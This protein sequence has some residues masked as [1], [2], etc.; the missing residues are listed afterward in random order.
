MKHVLLLTKIALTL[1][2]LNLYSSPLL[3]KVY[4]SVDEN[5][6]EHYTDTPNLDNKEIKVELTPHSSSGPIITPRKRTSTN[7]QTQSSKTKVS[8]SSPSN[9]QSVRAN[10]GN[11][12]ISSSAQ[13]SAPRGSQYQLQFDGAIVQTQSGGTFSLKQVNRGTHTAVVKLVSRNGR[14]IAAS[15]LVTF[16]ILKAG[17]GG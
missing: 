16:H 15:E 3:A 2:V 14:V 8:I 5:G 6:V 4:K 10:D 12:T 13:P 1:L 17:A 11:I 9:D 7:K